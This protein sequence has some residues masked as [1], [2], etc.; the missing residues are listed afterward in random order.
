M[1]DQSPGKKSEGISKAVQRKR[2]EGIGK[3]HK[4]KNFTTAECVEN[5]E[6]YDIKLTEDSRDAILRSYT[7]HLICSDQ[8]S[9]LI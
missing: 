7:A 1:Q 9:M 5:K 4:I 8:N 2:A 3:G 6:T